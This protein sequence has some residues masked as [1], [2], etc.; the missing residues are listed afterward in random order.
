MVDENC[1]KK[2]NLIRLSVYLNECLDA[3]NVS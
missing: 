3:T 1:K 2:K